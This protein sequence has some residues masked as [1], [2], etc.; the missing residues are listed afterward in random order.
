MMIQCVVGVSVSCVM[1]DPACQSYGQP[2]TGIA[3]LS[4]LKV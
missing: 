1:M 4:T 3:C 2:Y